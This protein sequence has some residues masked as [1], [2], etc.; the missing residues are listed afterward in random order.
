MLFTRNCPYK[1]ANQTAGMNGKDRTR[2]S[3]YP[4][5]KDEL[6]TCLGFKLRPLTYQLKDSQI[7]LSTD[8]MGY[9]IAQWLF[10]STMIFMWDEPPQITYEVRDK[11]VQFKCLFSH[12]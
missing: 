5:I 12:Q 6:E 9:L 2:V 7:I 3:S 10:T 11:Q 8:C 4:R 1:A